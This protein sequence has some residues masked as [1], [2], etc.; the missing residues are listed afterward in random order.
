MRRPCASRMVASLPHSRMI[1]SSLPRQ[2]SCAIGSS[3]WVSA[4]ELAI[5]GHRTSIAATGVER[6]ALLGIS[7]GAA[8]AI[9][10]AVRS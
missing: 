6:F 2:T 3:R 5:I 9:A 4:P 10:Y 7:Q 8:T 1:C